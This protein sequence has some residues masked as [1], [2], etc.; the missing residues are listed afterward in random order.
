MPPIPPQ[1]VPTASASPER[2]VNPP[3]AQLV[4]LDPSLLDDE[5]PFVYRRDNQTFFDLIA[6]IGSLIS[7]VAQFATFFDIQ[8][9]A[10]SGINLIRYIKFARSNHR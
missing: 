9:R 8:S 2:L 10:L 7:L 4:Q 6:R 5:N 3:I 1:T